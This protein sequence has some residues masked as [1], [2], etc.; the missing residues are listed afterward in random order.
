MSSAT[1]KEIRNVEGTMYYS[2][3]GTIYNKLKELRQVISIELEQE[4]EKHWGC[5]PKGWDE[6]C[7]EL[8]NSAIQLCIDKMKEVL[9]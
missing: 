5:M 4:F 6:E 1:N 3:E 8:F 2:V 9:K 7:E